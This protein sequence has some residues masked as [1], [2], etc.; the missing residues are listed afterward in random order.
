METIKI[1]YKADGIEDLIYKN[2]FNP[3]YHELI[4]HNEQPKQE[5]PFVKV[6]P[7]ARTAARRSRAKAKAETAKTTQNTPSELPREA[8]GGGESS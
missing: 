4:E 2:R 6:V 1:R 8:T 5:Q 3:L 7:K